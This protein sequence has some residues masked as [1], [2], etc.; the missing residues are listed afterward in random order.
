MWN[1][2]VNANAL[3]GYSPELTLLQFSGNSGNKRDSIRNFYGDCSG[4]TLIVV[5]RAMR[6]LLARA[7]AECVSPQFALRRYS[8]QYI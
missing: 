2:K 1:T 3:S 5:I 6:Q 8:S 7:G 4:L